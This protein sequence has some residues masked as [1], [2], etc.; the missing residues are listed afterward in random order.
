MELF[1]FCPISFGLVFLFYGI[2]T[3]MAFLINMKF[4]K[5]KAGEDKGVHAFPKGNDTRVNVMVHARFE[6]AY[7]DVTLATTPQRCITEG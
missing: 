6:I 1:Y 4:L 5:N 7:Y 3:F 2:L